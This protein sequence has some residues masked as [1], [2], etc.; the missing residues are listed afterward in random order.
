M[1]KLL[2][3]TDRKDIRE[4]FLGI[5]D[6]N[7]L[8][9]DP[10]A[11]AAEMTE[12]VRYLEW[13]GADAVAVD[14]ENQDT[15]LLMAHLDEHYPYLPI[16]RTH[17]RGDALRNELS[18]LR[19]A[20]D[21]LH[22]DFSDYDNNPAMT[23]ARLQ[24]EALH[25]LLEERIANREELASRLLMAR[26]PICPERPCLLFEFDLPEGA[27]FLESRWSH[28]FERLDLSLRANFFG[29]IPGPMVYTAALISPLRLRVLAC[30][31]EDIT[32]QELDLLSSQAQREV[33]NT[34]Q[35]VKLFM[36][37]ELVCTR[38]TALKKL[39]DLIPA[40]R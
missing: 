23:L 3:V 20:L 33:L 14:M 31:T 10:L 15:A 38:F 13:P 27:Q 36:D 34:A 26:S 29:H 8:M 4:A 37:L 28:G 2:L 22:G 24:N 32:D 1:Y 7:R 9:F 19:D 5:Q 18:L 30:S 11:I 16:L 40:A 12:A 17:R 21:Q 6:M 25:K 35:Q 39:D